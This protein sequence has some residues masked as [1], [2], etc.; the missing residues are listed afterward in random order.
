[1]RTSISGTLTRILAD[2]RNEIEQDKNRETAK[3]LKERLRDAI[4]VISFLGAL[5]SEK[6]L[7]AEI[8]ER[9]PSQGAMRP[10]N[11]AAAPQAH[12]DCNNVKA[13]SVVT[14]WSNF[15]ERMRGTPLP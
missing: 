4:P 2:T 9:S 14:S 15:C 10:E 6:A 11:V 12:K 5:S 8:K 7:I 1:M 13:R 3:Q